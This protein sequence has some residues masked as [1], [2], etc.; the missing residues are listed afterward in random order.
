MSLTEAHRR[1]AQTLLKQFDESGKSLTNQG[2]V[3]PSYR[4]L[5]KERSEALPELRSFLD[6]F[7]AGKL[8]LQGFKQENNVLS[9]KHNYW[10]FTGFSGQMTLNQLTNWSHGSEPMAQ[11][12]REALAVPDSKE[13]AV[14]KINR[15][16]RELPRLVTPDKRL[17]PASM[18][19]VLSYFWQIQRPDSIPVYY[20]SSKKTLVDSGLLEANIDPAAMY[21]TFWNLH[22]QLAK[23][24]AP[25][26]KPGDNKLWFV[27]HVL[28]AAKP[29]AEPTAEQPKRAKG[30]KAPLKTPTL[31]GYS[32]FVP[33]RLADLLT[34]SRGEG[35][36][37]DFEDRV[38]LA[39]QVLG[40]EVTKLGQ[41]TGR[42]PDGI[43]YCREHNYAIL[44]DAKGYK[45]GYGIGVDDRNVIEYIKTHERDLRKQGYANFYFCFVSA[46]FRGDGKANTDRIRRET[47]TKSVV[48]LSAE[49]LLQLVARKIE[50]PRDFELGD[51][52]DLLLDSGEL[53]SDRL[54]AFWED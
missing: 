30:I 54:E 8:D 17:R 24:Y 2:V 12:L 32:E 10:G 6:R 36:A 21:D 43:A 27:E 28:W 41:G 19:F 31:N 22:E 16:L 15:V 35:S 9:I 14:E 42:N 46:T 29:A 1:I 33:P 23:E 39:F 11:L 44:F 37:T 13:K 25:A 20:H 45:D 52:Q 3:Y 18:P 48:L 38:A 51:F 34:L 5:D 50:R 49:S 7:I 40:F 53:G 47:G 4:D 26:M